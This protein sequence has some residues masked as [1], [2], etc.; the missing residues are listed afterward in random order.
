MPLVTLCGLPGAGKTWLATR[1]RDHLV[2]L[3]KEVVLLSYDSEH[4]QRAQA[5]QDSR[6]EKM[7]RST[8]KHRVDVH[9]SAEKIVILDALNY[10][11]GCRYELFCMA[12]EL[13]TTHCVVFVDTPLEL[14]LERNN[15]RSGDR[16]P[17]EL[18]VVEAI[19]MRFEKPNAKNRWDAPLLRVAP[20][21]TSGTRIGDCLGEIERAVLHGKAP[22]AGIATQSKP[23]VETT[24]MQELDIVTNE[25]VDALIAHQREFSDLGGD[26]RVSRATTPISFQL[27]LSDYIQV[28]RAMATAELRRHRRQFIKISQLHPFAAAL[29]GNRFADYLN[30]QA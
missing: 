30:Q 9:L 11:K 14:A 5:Y 2:G 1:L 19:A 28:G 15:Q 17:N 24:F 16:F 20:E 8:M 12:K 27:L 4:L 23:V 7:T 6:A 3:G 22:K 10:I 26:V 13:S 21:D 18:S 25:I 29:V